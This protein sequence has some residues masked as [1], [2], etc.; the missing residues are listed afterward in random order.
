MP[1]GG[2]LSP[3]LANIMLNELDHELE[4]RGHKFVRY[5]DDMVIF[6]KSKASAEQALA[7]II[8]FIE[9]KLFL[10]VNRERRSRGTQPRLNSLVTAFTGARRGGGP[11]SMQRARRSA[12]RGSKS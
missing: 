5:A 6:C 12:G 7:H 1:Q 11:R 8:P 10:R 9:G 2:P 3:L 4:K